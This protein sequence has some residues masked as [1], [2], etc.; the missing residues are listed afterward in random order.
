MSLLL[1]FLFGQARS[2]FCRVNFGFKAAFFAQIC[3]PPHV[4]C[5]HR[6]SASLG[7]PVW[8]HRVPSAGGSVMLVTVEPVPL[9]A[10]SA[11]PAAVTPCSGLRREHRGREGDIIPEG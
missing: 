6:D 5:A 11:V 8:M 3:S 1:I 7:L 10:S 9:S 2:D 4:S